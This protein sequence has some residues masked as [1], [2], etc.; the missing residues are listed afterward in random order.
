MVRFVL[1]FFFFFSRAFPVRALGGVWLVAQPAFFSTLAFV[2]GCFRV[3]PP[4]VTQ[5]RMLSVLSYLPAPVGW[6]GHEVFLSALSRGASRSHVLATCS[7][8]T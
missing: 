6:L 4:Q 5:V 2:L 3:L 7:G 8:S 1:F